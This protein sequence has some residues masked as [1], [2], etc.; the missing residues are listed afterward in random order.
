MRLIFLSII[1]IFSGWT[2]TAQKTKLKIAVAYFNPIDANLKKQLLDNIA[3]TYNCTVSELPYS[4]K[5]P[6]YAYY[7]LRSRYRALVILEYLDLIEG[8]DK[9]IGITTKDICTPSNGIY[10]WG[11]MGLSSLP[12]QSCVISTYRMKTPNKK[13]F[14]D[15]FIKVALHE[16]GHAMGLSHCTFSRTCFME[17][18]EGTVKSVDRETRSLCSNCKRLLNFSK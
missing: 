18:A 5:L 3:A 14:N 7:S 12:G 2:G 4:V 6:S 11:V 13:L 16:L 15:R 10:D 8:Y 17:A 1:L 9:V